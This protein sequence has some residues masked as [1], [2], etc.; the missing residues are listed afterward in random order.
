MNAVEMGVDIRVDKYG[1]IMRNRW[2]WHSVAAINA[3][4]RGGVLQSIHCM[5]KGGNS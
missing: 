1:W 5:V 2:G 4:I 3:E